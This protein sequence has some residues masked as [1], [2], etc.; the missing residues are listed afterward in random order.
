MAGDALR[1]LLSVVIP[2]FN[3]TE[4]L[5]QLVDTLMKQQRVPDEVIIVDD[6]STDGSSEMIKHLGARLPSL[7][8]IRQEN[9]GQAVA[10]N[11][12]IRHATGSYLA[13][14]DVD[15]FLD[16]AAY[17]T[18]LG[19]A[20][21]EQLDVVMGNAWNFYEGRKPDTL[22]Y[23]D[24]PDTG[25]ITGEAWFQQRW[26]ARYLPHY[27]WMHL[28][29]RSFIDQ[30][31]F[32]FPIAD[33][34][35]DVVWVTETL[36]AARRIHFVPKPLFWYRRKQTWVFTPRVAAPGGKFV[37]HKTVEATMI[38]TL[39]LSEIA[40]REGLQPLTRKLIRREFVNGGCLIV[41]QIRRLSDPAQKAHY[42]KRIRQERFFHIL[43]RNAVGLS[44]YWR[45]FRYHVLAYA[46]GVVDGLK[47][48]QKA[49]LSPRR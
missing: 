1:P 42:L 13:F 31:G 2:V 18:L 4:Y 14:L 25:V 34:H 29:R 23:H 32:V 48:L 35:E 41:R 15:D 33:P 7:Q 37:R 45:V 10:R 17:V 20:E 43:W 11:L 6:G 19:L 3:G 44:Q 38:N 49:G 46:L 21:A 12:G 40:H 39:A 47:A 16:P 22:V 30:H 9:Q 36:L 26:L 24:V 8:V 27:C 28:Y 5:P